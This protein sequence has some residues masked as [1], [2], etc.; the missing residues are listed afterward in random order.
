V[1]VT[2]AMREHARLRA[3]KFE[4]YTHHLMSATVTLAIEG[5][6]HIA[7]FV[8]HARSRGDL[9]AKCQT[10]D[11]YASIDQ[12]ATKME[13]QLRK[14]EDRI[15]HRRDAARMKRSPDAMERPERESDVDEFDEE[16]A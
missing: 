9:V 5:D 7:E 6:R 1:D 10:H 11:M 15:K 4:K 12:A 8:A 2:D 3:Q 14:L 13:K 16:G